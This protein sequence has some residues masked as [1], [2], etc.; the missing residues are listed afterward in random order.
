MRTKPANRFN[1]QK[2]H[3]SYGV[4]NW[5]RLKGIKNQEVMNEVGYAFCQKQGFNNLSPKTPEKTKLNYVGKRF[6]KFAPFAGQYLKDNNYI[7]ETHQ[8]V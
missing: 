5:F 7:P 4:Y 3:N 6:E 2:E 1:S 8:K